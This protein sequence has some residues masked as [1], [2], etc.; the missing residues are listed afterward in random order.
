MM[1][2]NTRFITDNDYLLFL[3]IGY[4]FVGLAD[5][6]H[7]LFYTGM[8][9]VPWDDPNVPTQLWILSRSLES[10][11]LFISFAFLKRKI[12][13]LYTFAF[14]SLIAFTALLSV[15]YFKCFP[16]CYIAGKGLTAFKIG[17][18]YMICLILLS[19]I[20][21]CIKK[22]KEFDKDVLKMI[23]GAILFTVFSEIA[24][25]FYT[26]TYDFLNATGH[27]FK[28]ISFYLIYKAIIETGL[29]NPYNLLF[30][31][32]KDA[33]DELKSKLKELARSN[34]ELENFAHVVS[35]DLQAPLTALKGFLQIFYEE[36]KDKL[37]SRNEMLISRVVSNANR[38]QMFIK[39]LLNYA[40]VGNRGELFCK[41]DLNN[42]LETVKSNLQINIEE[43]GAQIISDKLPTL[44]CDSTQMAQLFQNLI[45]NALKFR[46]DD[47][48]VI[49]IS[50]VKKNQYWVIGV[51]DNGIGID[52]KYF[53]KLFNIFQR[54]HSIDEY[55]GSGVGLAIC[56]KIVEYHKGKIWLESKQGN[57]S[58]FYFS[59][60]ETEIDS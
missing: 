58:T 29:V 43:C 15:F 45:S 48:P 32:L 8:R 6:L 52:E 55:P 60:P 18:E 41:T 38:M 22:R 19:S 26:K 5:L 9:L 37:D 39:D 50:A 42:I 24:F 40:K 57:G 10:V 30:K 16:D 2:W 13:V 3:G 53:S 12:N 14:Y 49:Q 4:L 34:E 25:T 35:H 56:K 1:A 36:N 33:S 46:A 28:I 47:K 7:T 20:F 31:N 21:L 54:L 59:I 44:N 17:A 11:T 27:C 23:I 51:K